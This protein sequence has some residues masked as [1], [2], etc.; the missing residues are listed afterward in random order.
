VSATTALVG[1]GSRLFP[2]VPPRALSRFC[3]LRL[4]KALVFLQP[5]D[6]ARFSL[7]CVAYPVAPEVLAVLWLPLSLA[8][9][10]VC[11][12]GSI[13][14]LPFALLAARASQ[15]K[16]STEAEL[17]F[18]VMMLYVLSFESLPS[19]GYS[20]EKIA[21][22]GQEL[23][24]G[25]HSEVQALTRN[26]TYRTAP[27]EATVESTFASHP[28][29]QVREFVHGY[30][31]T[32]ASGRDAHEFVKNESE[33]FMGLLEERWRT[34]SGMVA[35]TTEI[36]FIFLAVF[37]IGL[38]MIAGGVMGG[39]ASDILLLSVVLLVLVT[40]SLLLWLDYAQPSIHDGRY[41]LLGV[42]AVT[43]S[44]AC[45][46]GLYVLRLISLTEAAVVGLAASFAFVL[47][48]REF[49]QRL[50]SGEREVVTMLHDLA[51]EAR[52]GVNIPAALSHLQENS[53]RYP[54]LAGPISTFV[55]LLSLGQSPKAAQRRVVHPSWLVRVSF[56]LLATAFETGS[57]YEQLDR[58]SA[59]FRRIHD[60][61]RNIQSSVL[62]FAVLGAAVPAISVASY[63]FL[64]S[65]QGFSLLVPGLSFSTGSLSI[66]A[67][68][69]AT[70]ILSGFVVSKAYSFSFRSL[71]GVPPIL[72]TA[73]VSLLFFGFA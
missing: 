54:S 71:V 66:G 34:F 39:G 58:L 46:L 63:W 42:G 24:P 16:R 18:V 12:L 10:V 43:S 56:G 17:P 70:S 30:L 2:L 13:Q 23:F 52:S 7:A 35:S 32:L 64:S 57:G 53:L 48:S 29:G 22:L 55:R 41:P 47:I 21:G 68:V 67:S 51:E 33:R 9:A 59:S 20:F 11:L 36:A 26:L 37:P 8:A 15:R 60:A 69:M 65:M 72:L 1:A 3:A 44:L 49:F 31:T 28:S 14:L 5:D 19:I 6:Y 4:E 38:Q 27:E 61:R 40:A 73:L 62:P 25:F 45:S 50:R